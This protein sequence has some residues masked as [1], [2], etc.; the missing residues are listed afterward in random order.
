MGDETTLR[1]L[2]YDG[3][4]FPIEASISQSRL[5]TRKLY[6]V[7]LR[8]VTQ[9]VQ[10]QAALTQTHEA[11]RQDLAELKLDVAWL[12]QNV[13]QR[14]KALRERLGSMGAALDRIASDAPGNETEA[15]PSIHEDLGFGAATEWLISDFSKRTGTAYGCRVDKSVQDIGEPLA[16]AL[17]QALEDSLLNVAHH[18]HVS[19]VD[20]QVVRDNGAVQLEVCDNGSD[21]SDA[22]GER[23]ASFGLR[24]LAQR[25]MVLGGEAKATR[26]ESGG[27]RLVFRVP[28]NGRVGDG[29]AHS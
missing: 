6:T 23:A 3:S 1:A 9:R 15:M 2:R 20:V 18:A 24:R 28:V 21:R 26:L 29:D 7:I 13:P 14:A 25:A 5:R 8:D 22:E 4:E 11:L 19:R 27:T 12:S 17:L 16:S 10:T